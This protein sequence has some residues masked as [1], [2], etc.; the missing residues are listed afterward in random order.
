ME[1]SDA[2]DVVTEL[3]MNVAMALAYRDDKIERLKNILR[4]VVSRLRDNPAQK[5]LSELALWIGSRMSTVDTEPQ[6]LCDKE[7]H[8]KKASTVAEEVREALRKVDASE[9]CR[10]CAPETLAQAVSDWKDTLT[11]EDRKQLDETGLLF[12]DNTIL[13]T[14]E[15]MRRSEIS[16]PVTIDNREA[17]TDGESVSSWGL[18][19]VASSVTGA[20]IAAPQICVCRTF[21]GVNEFTDEP[22]CAECGGGYP[23]EAAQ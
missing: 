4:V 6:L 9:G 21:S 12:K 18:Y 19:P 22:K 11:P 8:A 16:G 1:N 23:V 2:K 20:A 15:I 14:G 3:S 5:D 7:V 17:K 10:S 13:N